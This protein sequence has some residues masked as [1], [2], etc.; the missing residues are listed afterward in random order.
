MRWHGQDRIRVQTVSGTLRA[1][2]VEIVV[3]AGEDP[4]SNGQHPH[5]RWKPAIDQ[6]VRVGRSAILTPSDLAV[7]LVS[8][9]SLPRTLLVQ[10]EQRWNLTI[11]Q[12][13]RT[14]IEGRYIPPPIPALAILRSSL[15]KMP[16]ILSVGWFSSP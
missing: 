8:F 3:D 12:V 9:D 11:D 15:E 1:S 4:G 10:M 6:V 2:S 14:R 7:V 16:G 5:L 13:V